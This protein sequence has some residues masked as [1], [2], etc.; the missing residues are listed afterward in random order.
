MI[1]VRIGDVESELRSIND[2]W[3][4]QQINCR[5]TDGQNVCV[6]VFI[7][8][9]N[10]NMI[11]STPSCPTESSDRRPTKHEQEIFDYWEKYGL[12]KG[13]FTSGDLIAFLKKVKNI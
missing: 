13:Q 5:R 11:L 3:I 1:R 8:Q 7:Q 9:N 6:R 4:N 12:N 10:L 2:S